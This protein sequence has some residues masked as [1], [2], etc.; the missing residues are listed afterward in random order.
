MIDRQN[1]RPQCWH[2]GGVLFL[3]DSRK[4]N[5]E[6]DYRLNLIVQPFAM[7]AFK[8]H[9]LYNRVKKK[10]VTVMAQISLRVDDD[11]KRNAER[12]LTDIGLS[13][14][15]AINIFLKKVARENRIPFELSADPFYSQENMDELERR[16]ANVRAGKS[17][18]KEH[19]LIKVQ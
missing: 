14:S 5:P 17:T 4:L 6:V 7:L 2:T 10:G 1:E 13:M 16:V 18:L 3:F 9:L 8:L 15:T 19:D 12:T 11:V